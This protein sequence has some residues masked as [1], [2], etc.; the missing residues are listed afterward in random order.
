MSWLPYDEYLID[1]ISASMDLRDPNSQALGRVAEEIEEG[2]GREV[3]CDLATGVGKT[4]L[5]ASLIEYL[6][7]KG[8]RNVLFVTPGKT[9]YDKTIAN[10]TPGNRKFVAGAEYEPLLITAENFARGQVGDALHDP[11]QL[12]LFVFNVQQLIKPTVNTSRKTRA[13]D[14][15]IGGALYDHLREA[16]DLVII[17]DEHHVYNS[18]AKAFSNAIRDLSP[19]A[20][21][22][23]TA[24]PDPADLDKVIYRYTLAEAIADQL[25][26]VPVIVYRQDG[27]KDTHTQLADAVRLRQAKEPSWLA[28][29]AA[30]GVEA[31]LPVLF[32]VCQKIE[33]AEAVSG[34]LAELMPGE[35]EVLLITSQSSD[36][37]LAALADVESAYSPV[38]AIVSVDKLKE[39]WDVRNIGVIVGLRALASQTLTEQILGRGLRLPFGARTGISA[40]DQVDLV[41]HESYKELL[42]NKDALLERL[43]SSIPVDP[44]LPAPRFSTEE[45]DGVLRVVSDQPVSVAPGANDVLGG[46]SDADILIVSSI[47][48]AE[49]RFASES[50][51]INQTMPA[52]AGARHV[53]FPRRDRALVPV[54]FSLASL[55][56]VDVELAGRHYSANAT[57]V[58][59][60]DAI[61]ASRD[62][63]GE[64]A[65]R[66]QRVESVE[67]TQNYLPATRV[68][69]DLIGRVMNLGLV[70]ALF[71]ER[72]YAEDIVGAFLGGAGVIEGVETDWTVKRAAQAEAAIAALVRAAYAV[73]DRRPSYV[74]NQ[75]TLLQPRPL[76]GQVNGLY[77][78]YVTHEWYGG[79]HKN[80]EYASSFDSKT[81]EFAFAHLVDASDGVRWWL[82]LY[83]TDPAY[84]T[85]HPVGRYYPDFI[86]IDDDGVNWL[87]ETKSDDAALNDTKVAA[88]AAAAGA[89]VVAVN[90]SKSF[91][92]WRYLLVTETDIK[93]SSNWKAV[94]SRLG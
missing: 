54:Q 94:V 43:V 88:K 34:I 35:G 71:T 7:Q 72:V 20:L 27:L 50:R 84:I 4:Y 93:E 74:W 31:V 64:A 11:A 14:E 75:V 44:E 52:V 59:V 55:R 79:W 1:Q 24:T 58:M 91:G 61:D 36:D 60:R 6:A 15:F 82:R 8:V 56:L 10:F 28:W 25:V 62:L 47:E 37:A 53:V 2:T 80:A 26:K 70:P 29:A 76:P 77:D 63:E 81:G 66:V 46:L 16:G 51:S 49:E 45:L 12:K 78:P 5:A 3:I 89:W 41:A 83:T 87:I 68:R 69:T 86:V 65:I 40:I 67:A 9:I 42:R 57:E 38:R 32:V 17:A 73:N 19:R 92:T 30:R 48:D 33:D 23:L 85:L 18:N 21:V 22:G 13:D 90:E 39:G